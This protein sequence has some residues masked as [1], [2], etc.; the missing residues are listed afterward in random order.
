[1]I[2]PSDVLNKMDVDVYKKTG[3]SVPQACNAD[4]SC[5]FIEGEEA[6]AEVYFNTTDV[7]DSADG[8]LTA[9]VFNM[10]VMSSTFCLPTGNGA[11]AESAF[12]SAATSCSSGVPLGSCWC[13]AL[14]PK[15][16]VGLTSLSCASS[17]YAPTCETFN[18]TSNGNV[19][20]CNGGPQGGALC[21]ANKDCNQDRSGS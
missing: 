18:C 20:R 5:S 3:F 17:R 16:L 12:N 11:T 14:V 10:D 21:S 13:N 15:R 8:K 1:M 2:D 6:Y 19:R 9:G 7:F 4:N